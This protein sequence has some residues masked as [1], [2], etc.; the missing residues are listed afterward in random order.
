M[1]VCKGAC[2]RHSQERC[3]QFVLLSQQ[4]LLEKGGK[5]S[6]YCGECHA[7]RCVAWSRLWVLSPYWQPQSPCLW[8]CFW[9]LSFGE[10]HSYDCTLVRFDIALLAWRELFK[11]CYPMLFP[12]SAG[13]GMVSQS[14]ARTRGWCGFG[15]WEGRVLHDGC[16]TMSSNISYIPL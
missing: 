3:Q 2:E 15:S 8:I 11:I 16:K 13:K 1:C 10:S 7:S 4:K 14:C 6:N 5:C 12:S 9:M